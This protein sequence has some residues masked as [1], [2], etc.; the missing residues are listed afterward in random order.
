MESIFLSDTDY[1]Q[2]ASQTEDL[3][4]KVDDLPYPKVKDDVQALLQNFDM[5]HREA[6]TRLFKEIIINY[7]G[8]LTGTLVA[9]KDYK[10]V[11]CPEHPNFIKVSFNS[12]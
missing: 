12:A 2:L 1:E 3:V 7:L 11:H 10:L 4:A 5:L 6:L 8:F 9:E